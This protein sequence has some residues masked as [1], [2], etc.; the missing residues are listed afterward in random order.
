MPV[1]GF[2]TLIA[3]LW[4]IAE[5]FGV[6]IQAVTG[7]SVAL[8]L[9]PYWAFGFGFDTWLRTRLRGRFAQALAPVSLTA[10][11]LV[12]ALPSGAFHWKMCLGLVAIVL[13][14][15]LLLQRAGADPDWHDWLVLALLGISVDLH[16]FDRAWPVA[17]LGGTRMWDRRR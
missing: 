4:L 10:P 9:A 14:I 13:A 6:T 7:V 16:I 12:F 1:V 5:H 2:I 11:Y 8:L 17:G 3:C 15:T